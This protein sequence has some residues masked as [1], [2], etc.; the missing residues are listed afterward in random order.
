MR[1]QAQLGA[2]LNLLIRK[3]NI[4]IKQAT[5]TKM[6]VHRTSRVAAQTLLLVP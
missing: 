3:I 5:T 2:A 6:R 1:I 4:K